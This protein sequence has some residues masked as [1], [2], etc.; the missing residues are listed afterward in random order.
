MRFWN[1]E[2]WEFNKH[3]TEYWRET[4][5]YEEL[6]LPTPVHPKAGE[7]GLSTWVGFITSPGFTDIF[8]KQNIYGTFKK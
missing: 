6:L 3:E 8:I 7:D 4:E 5:G 1:Y 2:F